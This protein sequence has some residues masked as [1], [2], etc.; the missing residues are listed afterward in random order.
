MASKHMKRCSTSYVISELRIKTKKY[1]YTSIRMAKIQILT[2]KAGEDAEQPK[3]THCKWEC[4][5]ILPLW[6]MVWQFH[7]KQTIL[8]Q[9]NPVITVLD[10]CS[11]VDIYVQMKI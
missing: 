7:T 11:N 9:Y 1:H 2:T 3:L 8:L 6:E 4:K 10:I 5:M